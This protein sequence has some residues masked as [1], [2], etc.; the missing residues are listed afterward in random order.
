MSHYL[1]RAIAECE[2]AGRPLAL[3]VV[4]IDELEKV[5]AALGFGASTA[6]AD[7]FCAR[8]REIL[9][10]DDQLLQVGDRKF[11]VILKGLKNQGHAEL[12]ANKFARIG[13]ESF[14]IGSHL[15]KLQT[16]IGIAMFPEHATDVEELSRRADLALT[17]A[18][19]QEAPFCVYSDENTREMASLWQIENELER[20]L[21][22]SEFELYFQAKIDLKSMSPCGAEAL[23]RWNNPGRGLL[24][25][26]NFLAIAERAGKMEPITWFV[27]DAAQRQRFEWPPKWGELPVSV[28]IPPCV[29]D[30][31]KL[32][33]YVRDSMSIWGSKPGHLVL[34]I[35][36]DAVVRNPQ[37]SFAALSQLRKEGIRVSIDDFGTGYSSMTYFKDMP[38]DEIKID[39][40]FIKNLASDQGN[41]HIVRAIIDLAHAFDYKV[42]AEGVEAEDVLHILA[43]MGCDIVQGFLFSRPQP[44]GE[45]IPWLTAYERTAPVGGA[46]ALGVREA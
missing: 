13:K 34:E 37:R 25:P 46:V 31:G 29:L 17:T 40:S 8:V 19:E 6:L 16:V 9:R 22:E 5:E 1:M 36:E 24:L 4:Q 33:K 11:W 18:R 43:D 21:E 15:L 41:Q 35:T 32:I 30:S 12:A 39:K 23:L 2:A 45:F 20:A 28:N 27:I 14:R 7:D 3:L 38:T 10:N 26:G 42:V 44:Q